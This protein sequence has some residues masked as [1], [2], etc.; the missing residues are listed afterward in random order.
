MSWDTC[1]EMAAKATSGGALSWKPGEAKKLVVVGEPYGF[2]QE[3]I[4]EDGKK[5]TSEYQDWGDGRKARFRINAAVLE[6]NE[7]SM[8]KWN[9]SATVYKD[10]LKVKKKYGVDIFY[11]VE[12]E[13]DGMDTTYSILPDEK[14][15][16]V[17]IKAVSTLTPHILN[18][19]RKVED[20]PEEDVPF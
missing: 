4:V 14:L 10:L 6:N 16:D 3:Y 19:G 17:Q 1:E 12:R 20:K 18:S 9:M 11:E 15:T 2:Y 13:G 5:R 8:K 7:W